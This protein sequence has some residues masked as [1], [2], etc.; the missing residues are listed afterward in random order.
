MSANEIPQHV[1]ELAKV[2]QNVD[3][4]ESVLSN[5]HY[6]GKPSLQSTNS[7]KCCSSSVDHSTQQ[8]C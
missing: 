8:C 7:Y 6:M 1:W 5:G 2:N 3:D 4:G